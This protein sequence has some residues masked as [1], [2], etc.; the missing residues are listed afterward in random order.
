MKEDK[1]E[2][3]ESVVRMKFALFMEK[4]FWLHSRIFHEPGKTEFRVK[5]NTGF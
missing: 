4:L 2:G 1:E 5:T 3:Q